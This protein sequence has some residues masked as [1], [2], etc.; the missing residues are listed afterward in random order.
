[1][2]LRELKVRYAVKRD[3]EGRPV[4]IGRALMTP[5]ES[6]AVLVPLLQLDLSLDKVMLQDVVPKN[7]WSP[8]SSVRSC[9]S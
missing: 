6:A 8:S 7:F 3:D 2:R 9:R 4:M 5:R 1:M